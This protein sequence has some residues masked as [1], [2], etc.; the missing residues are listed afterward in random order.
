[1]KP[2][3]RQT[4]YGFS[5]LELVAVIVIISL[6]AVIAIPQVGKMYEA[7][8]LSRDRQNAQNIAAMFASAQAAGVD[9]FVAGDELATISAVVEGAKFAGEGPLYDA[10]FGVPGISGESQLSASAYLELDDE[11]RLLVYR[12]K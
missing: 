5:L 8:S 1:M 9:F 10:H 2:N 12:V 3:S 6:M 4:A 7:S 11:Q